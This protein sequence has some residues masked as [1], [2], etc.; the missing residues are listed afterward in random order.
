MVVV[1]EHLERFQTRR[2]VR[3]HL[4]VNRDPIDR[5]DFVIPANLPLKLLTAAVLAAIDED[6]EACDLA[7]EAALLMAPY[8]HP[9]S[10]ERVE[11]LQAAV[12]RLCRDDKSLSQITL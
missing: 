10:L 1:S 9:V 4:L 12:A 7:S 2:D 11:R 8:R 5:R 3:N 6:P